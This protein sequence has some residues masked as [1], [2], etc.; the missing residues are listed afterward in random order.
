MNWRDILGYIQAKLKAIDPLDQMEKMQRLNSL[1]EI[2]KLKEAF[3]F[4]TTESI[5]YQP[6][7]TANFIEAELTE[8]QPEHAH[9][10][11]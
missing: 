3:L 7:E 11:I 2:Q 10:F 6:Q 5:E 4:G 8:R 9:E 1:E